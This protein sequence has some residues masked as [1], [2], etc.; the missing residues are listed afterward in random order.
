MIRKIIII[1]NN[2]YEYELLSP[3][4]FESNYNYRIYKYN[5]F[6]RVIPFGL[7]LFF[8]NLFIYLWAGTQ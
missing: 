4:N 6:I 3:C 2:L 5:I 8:I 7:L 1:I